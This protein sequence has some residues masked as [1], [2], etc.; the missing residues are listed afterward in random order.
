[1]CVIFKVAERQGHYISKFLNSG[2]D[3]NKTGSF[4]FESMGMLAYI[5]RYEGISDTPQLKFTGQYMQKHLC[6]LN[7][8]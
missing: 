1:M 3:E 2:C 6:F 8:K 4:T 7:Y 5:G